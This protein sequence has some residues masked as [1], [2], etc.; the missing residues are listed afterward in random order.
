[1]VSQIVVE[2]VRESAEDFMSGRRI[3]AFVE[4]IIEDGV[5]KMV[6]PIA[7]NVYYNAVVSR[8]NI[9]HA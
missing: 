3:S 8:L 9:Y 1:M 5:V 2:A 6:G 4:D 7:S